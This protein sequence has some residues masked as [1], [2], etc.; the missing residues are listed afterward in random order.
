[1]KAKQ[2]TS[3]LTWLLVVPRESLQQWVVRGEGRQRGQDP[4]LGRGLPAVSNIP[5]L[6][7]PSLVLQQTGAVLVL[8]LCP[9][10]WAP[11][12]WDVPCP[13]QHHWHPGPWVHL[14]VLSPLFL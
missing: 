1:M 7:A 12:S 4:S 5:A 6:G 8:W 14:P 2:N 13:A 9:G 3:S 10:T 11:E